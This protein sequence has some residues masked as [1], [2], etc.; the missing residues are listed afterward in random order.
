MRT[1]TIR[2]VAGVWRIA[3]WVGPRDAWEAW[4]LP[5]MSW[6][7]TD[8]VLVVG[9]VPVTELADR[10]AEAQAAYTRV[11]ALVGPTPAVVLSLIHI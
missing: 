4:D 6:A 1:V 8:S 10:A 11:S 3:R 5:G 7:R 2:Q 9:N